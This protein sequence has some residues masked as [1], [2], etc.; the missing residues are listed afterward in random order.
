M[1]PARGTF[2]QLYPARDTLKHVIMQ[3]MVE[4]GLTEGGENTASFHS[5]G[6]TQQESTTLSWSLK[7]H[8][9]A[10]I[11]KVFPEEKQ[12]LVGEKDAD[13]I[14]KVLYKYFYF[15]HSVVLR[16]KFVSL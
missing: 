1:Y 10:T 3:S 7:L 15:I 6:W 5:R 8:I 4:S 2:E 14:R 16:I 11:F 9:K 13:A 12:Q